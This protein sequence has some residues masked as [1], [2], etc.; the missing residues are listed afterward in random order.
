MSKPA[1]LRPVR[2][3]A[4]KDAA[5]VEAAKFSAP[6][7]ES[8]LSIRV[9]RETLRSIRKTAVLSDKKIKRFVLDAL[10]AQGV[11]VAAQD[12]TDTQDT[13]ED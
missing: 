6:A 8:R 5:A 2:P 4:R 1:A 7:G 10:I 9:S 11:E 13:G 3:S 12:L